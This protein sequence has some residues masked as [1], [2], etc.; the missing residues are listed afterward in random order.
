MTLS[1]LLAH[2]RSDP[3]VGPNLVE[4]RILPGNPA[5]FGPFP[6]DIH[7]ALK[8]A[9]EARG[10]HSLYT[11]Q[12]SSFMDIKEGKN[13][14][15]VTG[16]ASGKTLCYILPVLDCL[17]KEID[18]TAL[19][20]FPTK[21]L[22]QDQNAVLK[23]LLSQ[24]NANLGINEQYNIARDGIRCA[25][26]DGDT[27]VS[28]RSTLR[29]QVRLIITNPDMLHTGI[30]PH[31]TSWAHFFRGLRYV[32]IDEIHTYRGVFGS[33]VANVIRR[34]KRIARHYGSIPVFILTS[35]TIANPVELAEWL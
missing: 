4:W 18:A 14:V 30:L 27:P 22:S 29:S 3:Q 13:V 28:V 7:P 20:L 9:L 8:E 12:V 1:K 31:H 24:I 6:P 35:A 2:W 32:V 17:L 25:I 21:A 11:H 23:S 5:R 16:T 10:I 34:L 15:I 26:Y 33:H 19:F